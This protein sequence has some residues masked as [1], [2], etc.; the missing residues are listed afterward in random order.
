[1][2]NDGFV[3]MDESERRRGAPR[4]ATAPDASDRPGR[5]RGPHLVARVVDE[6]WVAPTPEEPTLA[7]IGA[8]LR[9]W[10]RAK[11]RHVRR[12]APRWAL[13]RLAA[14]WSL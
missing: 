7:E 3:W 4:R 2:G 10:L 12:E 11:V 5:G 14:R 8:Q 6:A 1:M 13:D 9:L